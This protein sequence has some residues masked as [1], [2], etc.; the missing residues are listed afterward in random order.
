MKR[1]SL[2]FILLILATLLAAGRDVA[3]FEIDLHYDIK[4]KIAFAIGWP[5]DDAKII[6]S[7]DQGLD[8]NK[9]TVASIMDIVR[10]DRERWY[11]LHCFSRTDDTGGQRDP[12]VLGAMTALEN[13]ANTAINA[14]KNS[15]SDP[16]L[17]TKAL[18]AIGVYLHCQ[19]DSWSHLGYGGTFTG[20][21]W[22][23]IFGE[24]PDNPATDP[25]K[26]GS[27]LRETYEKL[28]DFK[29]RLD[30]TPAQIPITDLD[31]LIKGV[32]NRISKSKDMNYMDRRR[33]NTLIAE[34]WLYLT[35]EK[36][37]LL[38]N[39]SSVPLTSTELSSLKQYTYPNKTYLDI[40]N[41]A[42][43][44]FGTHNEMKIVDPSPGY[45]KLD[46][47]AQPRSV[48]TST[49]DYAKVSGGTFDLKTGNLYVRQYPTETGCH[50]AVS[51]LAVN[52]GLNTA[53]AASVAM[54]IMLPNVDYLY[55]VEV[56]IGSLEPSARQS[57]VGSVEAPCSI[58]Y[59]AL[60]DI[61]PPAGFPINSMSWDDINIQN[62]SVTQKYPLIVKTPYSAKLYLAP[63]Y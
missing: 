27:A 33:G 47:N 3:A 55:G 54:G 9:E 15:P 56:G 28:S 29:Q 5:W 19:E 35:L 63:E 45:P 61:A 53:P 11:D 6:A 41:D 49:G 50:Y 51:A 26:T 58:T 32:T 39:L 13:K 48:S 44:L 42:F 14:S 25:T 10:N 30:G 38:G 37:G 12:G 52:V 43:G 20:H 57:V 17:K 4:F 59:A 8:E 36:H 31:P 46:P 21:G 23:S 40:H 2:V 62:D 34:H 16:A 1:K 22:A 60:I 24:D 18:I 7:A